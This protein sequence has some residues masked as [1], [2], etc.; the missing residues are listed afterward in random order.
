MTY[1]AVQALDDIDLKIATNEIRAQFDALKQTK[2]WAQYEIFD[3]DF[4]GDNSGQSIQHAISIIESNEYDYV[5][6]DMPGSLT[7]KY[8]AELLELINYMIIPLYIGN[9]EVQST[10]DFCTYIVQEIQQ[11]SS[12]LCQIR[13]MFNMYEQ[14]KCTKCDAIE[15]ELQ[16]KLQIAFLKTR[17]KDSSYYRTKNN[18]TLVPATYKINLNTL[19]INPTLRAGNLSEFADELRKLVD[20]KNNSD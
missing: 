11:H 10:L 8:T 7:Q 17:V 20:L 16:D 13:M 9:F 19:K 1:D 5:F 4:S 2:Q 6:L 18:N 12:A 14:T 3:G 15:R